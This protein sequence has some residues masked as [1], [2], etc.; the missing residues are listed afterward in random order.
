MQKKIHLTNKEIKE[1]FKEIKTKKEGIKMLDSKAF[2][3]ENTPETNKWVIIDSSSK[4]SSY[5]N[6]PYVKL[7]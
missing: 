1:F 7:E 3:M 6:S 4:F 2:E 5:L